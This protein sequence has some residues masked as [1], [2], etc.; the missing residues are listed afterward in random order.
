MPID[1]SSRH[2]RP[3]VY[4]FVR[5][6][7]LCDA[8]MLLAAVLFLISSIFL[9]PDFFKL[10]GMETTTWIMTTGSLLW[11]VAFPFYGCVAKTRAELIA[12][13]VV[14]VVGLFPFDVGLVFFIPKFRKSLGEPYYVA[15]I[16]LFSLG[17]AAFLLVSALGFFY[18]GYNFVVEN[19][20]LSFDKG[21]ELVWLFLNFLGSIC[22]LWGS[23]DLYNGDKG[24]ELTQS[25]WLFIIGSAFF[26]L[27]AVMPYTNN[28]TKAFFFGPSASPPLM[29][30][31]AGASKDVKSY[32]TFTD[33]RT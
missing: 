17:S 10:V 3:V 30:A 21:S 31:E 7:G 23:I 6:G 32:Q 4:E 11:T 18:C 2:T 12:N 13:A 5:P 33:G 22:F 9:L 15:G 14:T 16:H 28:I 8:V 29:S 27:T 1:E 19:Q 25:A 20:R 26:V 24:I